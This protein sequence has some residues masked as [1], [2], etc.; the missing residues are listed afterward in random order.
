MTNAQAYQ[1]RRALEL[2]EGHVAVEIAQAGLRG[3]CLPILPLEIAARDL[4][5][6]VESGAPV[7]GAA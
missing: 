2:I 1:I 5:Q 6:V 3:F 4:R 7:G